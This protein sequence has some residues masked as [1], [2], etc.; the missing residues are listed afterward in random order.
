MNDLTGHHSLGG[1]YPALLQDPVDWED[2]GMEDTPQRLAEQVGAHAAKALLGDGAKKYFITVSR[3]NALKRLHLSG[4]YVKPDRCHEVIHL[5]E[6]NEGD[7]D[8][9]LPCKERMLAECGK[10]SGD[11]SSSTAS[12]SSTET[13]AGGGNGA[14]GSDQ[15]L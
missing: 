4:C 8:S 2:V 12:S 13:D 15:E 11:Q 9:I 3:R 10:D 14:H 5:D 1:T 7:F 6:V